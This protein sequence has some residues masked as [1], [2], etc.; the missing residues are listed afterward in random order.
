[1]NYEVTLTEILDAKE[2]RVTKRAELLQKYPTVI[3]VSLNVAGNI[4]TSRNYLFAFNEAIFQIKAVFKAYNIKIEQLDIYNKKTGDFAFAAVHANALTVKKLMV[5]I[6]ENSK[7]GRLFDLDVSDENDNQIS[8][9]TLDLPE[10]KCLICGKIGRGCA[11]S[12]AH[13]ITEVINKTNEII[14]DYLIKKQADIIAAN[15]VKAL[16]YE[17]LSA[18]KPGLVDRF[19]SGSHSDMD[20]FT[21]ANSSAALYEYFHGCA[22][23]AIENIE[24]SHRELFEKIRFLGILAESKMLAATGNVNTHKGMIFSLGILCAVVGRLT[25]I[26]ELSLENIAKISAE[27]AKNALADFEREHIANTAGLSQYSQFQIKGIRGEAA[28]GFPS[29]IKIAYPLLQEKLA[30]GH[31]INDA[32]LYALCALIAITDD[33]TIVKRSGINK[34][35]EI[36]E[37]FARIK[38]SDNMIEELRAQNAE[39]IKDNISAGGSADLLA[40]TLF[41]H[42]TLGAN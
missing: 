29:V 15:A 27:L 11:R 17:V 10:R 1:M 7:L 25:C 42:F 22:S 13:E 30:L 38:D 21:F 32:C 26:N 4:K 3:T 37:L 39:F 31:S 8:R 35:T 41:L 12:K 5:Q 23:C 14:N 28:Q 40:L 9:T 6:E 18:P 20:I 2:E 36:K 19:D 16:I 24:F 33:S 34:L